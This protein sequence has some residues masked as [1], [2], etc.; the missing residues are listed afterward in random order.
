MDETHNSAQGRD[1]ARKIGNVAR[2]L[3]AQDY[4]AWDTPSFTRRALETVQEISS[5]NSL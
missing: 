2:K 1:M 5:E 3:A 4:F